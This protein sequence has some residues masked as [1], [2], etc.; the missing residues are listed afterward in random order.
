MASSL[1]VA[2]SREGKTFPRILNKL[3]FEPCMTGLI[4][5]LSSGRVDVSRGNFIF[6]VTRK[7]H[8][9]FIWVFFKFFGSGK[10]YKT[11]GPNQ[12]KLEF[13]EFFSRVD[14]HTFVVG[15]VC[16]IIPTRIVVDIR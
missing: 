7:H 15:A 16:P 10:L 6:D 14:A 2:S 1:I 5:W 3:P 4:V 9:K 13:L 12:K 11:V 8:E